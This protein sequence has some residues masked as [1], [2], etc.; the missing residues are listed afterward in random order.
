MKQNMTK[1]ILLIPYTLL[2]TLHAK[3]ATEA[4][5]APL[6]ILGVGGISATLEILRE[7]QHTKSLILSYYIKMELMTGL[8][9]SGTM[10]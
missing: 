5:K 9:S 1:H 3:C 10:I 6:H 8:S 7:N 4:E 2:P